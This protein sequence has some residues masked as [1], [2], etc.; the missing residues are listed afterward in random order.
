MTKNNTQNMTKKYLFFFFILG[1]QVN[2]F[3]QAT[4]PFDQLLSERFDESQYACGSD[5]CVPRDCNL[6]SDCN[7]TMA[8]VQLSQLLE[9]QSQIVNEIASVRTVAC[10]GQS[11]IDQYYIDLEKFDLPKTLLRVRLCDGKEY[12]LFE[13]YLQGIPTPIDIIQTIELTS[14]EQIV[15]VNINGVSNDLTIE[16][17]LELVFLDEG[18]EDDD[19]ILEGYVACGEILCETMTEVC[20]NE[21]RFAQ[22][23]VLEFIETS[24]ESLDAANLSYPITLYYVTICGGRNVWL[25]D[26]EYTLLQ[27]EVPTATLN[28]VSQESVGSATA[29]IQIP[30]GCAN[31]EYLKDVSV[32]GTNPRCSEATSGSIEISLRN[33]ATNIFKNF[34]ID[35]GENYQQSP[36]FQNLPQG[37]YQV[38][39]ANTDLSFVVNWPEEIILVTSC[40][41]SGASACSDGIDNDEDGLIDCNDADCADVNNCNE[42]LCAAIPDYTYE[43][44]AETCASLGQIVF[45]SDAGISVSFD[46]LAFKSDGILE[47]ESGT[48][49]VFISWSADGFGC[50]EVIENIIIPTEKPDINVTINTTDINICNDQ[51]FGSIEVETNNTNLSFSIDEG[52][53]FQQSPLF[54]NLPEGEYIITIK[55]NESQCLQLETASI[56]T[57]DLSA[58]LVGNLMENGDIVFSFD[59]T[60]DEFEEFISSNDI[61]SLDVAFFGVYESGGEGT[62][63]KEVP[64]NNISTVDIENWVTFLKVVDLLDYPIIEAKVLVNGE[65]CSDPI[66]ISIFD[67]IPIPS[68][69][70]DEPS[71]YM[72]DY[73]A[74]LLTSPTC[75]EVMVAGFPIVIDQLDGGG[76]GGVFSGA[77]RVPLPFGDNVIEVVFSG[78]KINDKCQIVEGSVTG[79]QCETEGMNFKMFEALDIGGD[80]CLPPPPPPGYNA[81]GVDAATGLDPYGFNANGINSE[82]GTVFDKNGFDKNG[83]H[84]DTGTEFNEDGCSR[85]GV[86]KDGNACELLGGVNE[87]A[88]KYADENEDAITTQINDV[89]SMLSSGGTAELDAKREECTGHKT[90]MEAIVANTKVDPMDASSK[91]M[92]DEVIIFGN[93]RRFIDEGMSTHFARPPE[94]LSGGG[95]RRAEA[96]ELERLHVALYKCDVQLLEKKELID[97]LGAT[98]PDGV[99][100]EDLLA[101]LFDAILHWTEYQYELFTNDEA[102]FQEWLAVKIREYEPQEEEGEGENITDTESKAKEAL[103][104]VFD[105]SDPSPMENAPKSRDF[106][107]DEERR[108]FDKAFAD[109]ATKINGVDRVFYS[110]E[111]FKQRFK[112]NNTNQFNQLPLKVTNMDGDNSYDIFIE[113]ITFGPETATMSAAMN[114]QNNETGAPFTFRQDNIPFTPGGMSGEE[115]RLAIDRDINI[116]LNNAAKLIIYSEG[117]YVLWDCNGFKEFGIAAGVEFCENIIQPIEDGVVQEGRVRLEVVGEHIESWDEFIFTLNLTDEGRQPISFIMTQYESVYWTINDIVLDF[118]S[119]E[120]PEPVSSDVNIEEIYFPDEWRGFFIG[121]LSATLGS[122]FIESPTDP[123]VTPQEDF[124][125]GVKNAFIDDNGFSGEVFV[126]REL[127]PIEE[128]NLGEWAFSIDKLHLVAKNNHLN[129]GG[130]SGQIQIPIVDAPWDY[131]AQ[132]FPGEIYRLTVNPVGSF[133]SPNFKSTLELAK[134][135]SVVVQKDETGVTALADLSGTLVVNADE[136]VLSKLDLP[137]FSFTNFQISNKSPHFSPG[138]WDKDGGEGTG[139]SQSFNGFTIRVDGIKPYQPKDENT[140]GLG[141][142]IEIILSEDPI[143]SAKG[144]FGVVSELGEDEKGRQKWNY[145]RTD[146]KSLAI[147]ADIKSFAHIKG[148]IEY[149]TESEEWGTYYTGGLSVKIYPLS[150]TTISAIGQFGSIE[151]ETDKT[152]Y[153]YVDVLAD[154]PFK[155]PIGPVNIDQLGLGLY[156]NMRYELP[157]QDIQNFN[158]EMMPSAIPGTP[159]APGVSL[160]A[161]NYVVDPTINLG[162]KGMARFSTTNETVLNGSVAI[163]AEFSQGSGS[164]TRIYLNG[165]GQMLATPNPK[166]TPEKVEDEDFNDVK[167]S[168]GEVSP[169]LKPKIETAIAAFINIDYNIR[170]K[171]FHG[172]LYGF[173]DAGGAGVQINA[174]VPGVIHFAPDEWYIYLG[175]PSD[176]IAPGPIKASLSAGGVFDLK[177]TAYFCIGTNV[178]PMAEIPES[179]SAIAYKINRN[180]TLRTTGQGLVMGANVDADASIGL[181]GF[182]EADLRAML[183]FDLMVRKYNNVTCK[184]SG[185]EIGI[186]GWYASGQMYG[187][188]EGALKVLGL[189]VFEAGVAAVLQAQLPNPVFAQAT[190]GVRAKVAFITIKKSLAVSIGTPCELVAENPADEFGMNIITSI[191]PGDR[192][193]DVDPLMKARVNFAVQLDRVYE[194]EFGAGNTNTYK[195]I[196]ESIVMSDQNGNEIPNSYKIIDD[197]YAAEVTPYY[198]LPSNEEVSIVAIVR[199]IKNGETLGDQQEKTVTFTTKEGLD[200]IPEINIRNAYPFD[201]MSHYHKKQHHE[202]F[203][204]LDIGQPE[205]FEGET[206]MVMT[207]NGSTIEIPIEYQNREITYVIPP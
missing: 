99:A 17:L 152:K 2:I 174:V 127:I 131:E 159:P 186:N 206:Y 181:A 199:L 132:I 87:A 172:T 202:N 51:Q 13:E 42:I 63:I 11:N 18:L 134:T 136:G 149:G 96:K 121:E 110:K 29:T 124:T 3:A 98:F 171:V 102:K 194:Y 103:E 108:S 158:F 106:V 191:T 14:Y 59:Y 45:A 20:S 93:D 200:Y 24:N 67:E 182:V 160:S 114:V 139:V 156:H 112:S 43:V 81:E 40:S 122:N 192:V 33:N 189:N 185:D 153:F 163:G 166:I 10:D 109:G 44:T 203:I 61:T 140:V 48:Y 147:D 35:G 55:D 89:L 125:I 120:S 205:L 46:G 190:I 115:T 138:V 15:T 126:D 41:E 36:V 137:K 157:K 38:V 4:L 74:P 52:V 155:L 12:Y 50:T 143:I 22:Q 6:P 82:T 47:A 76:E 184:G 32:T 73:D 7:P 117:T 145:L 37:N 84:K 177:G 133:Y 169:S 198:S 94:I 116:R 144:G 178:P 23:E 165:S 113:S 154:L 148:S 69:G 72:V 105:F 27:E 183:G 173:F 39:L 62:F 54:Q 77:G 25:L 71:D 180:E 92:F 8:A 207:G 111:I 164:L 161:G 91:N 75:Q 175:T 101:Y 68:V 135:S 196:I 1:M 128:G 85:Q 19:I 100:D 34:S 70:C 129:G 187:L 64:V 104:K 195:V 204:S 65:T 193:E 97:D 9:Q 167:M 30:E 57:L 49:D 170:D 118:S 78:V 107:S 66:E 60:Q 21:D 16:A 188:I 86:D 31:D 151:N 119:S 168:E 201:N 150:E 83:T 123:G 26:N 141:F 88:Q 53:T 90:E 80:I 5:D 142:N 130:F 179:V 146:I 58:L 56:K 95:V 176:E 197:G 28:I 162:I 79:V